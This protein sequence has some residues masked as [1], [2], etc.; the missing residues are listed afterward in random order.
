MWKQ[1]LALR[2]VGPTVLVS[3]LLL[4]L[5]VAAAVYLYGQQATSAAILGENVSSNQVAHDLEA[6]L[7]DLQAAL[8]DRD[9]QLGALHRRAR[10]Q[11]D[12]ARRLADKPR[13]LELVDE[14]EA[15]F[16]HYLE[17]GQATAAATGI[18]E[19]EAL[20]ICRELREFN[21]GLARTSEQEHRRTVQ[22]LA[23]GVAGI[24]GF[25]ALAGLAL[26]LAAARGLRRSIH[27]LSVRVRDAADK[28]GQ[29]L[30]PV[31]LT[32]PADLQ[33]LQ[34]QLHGLV[35]EITQVV[36]KLHQ[37]EREV[38]RAEQLA[39]VGQLAAGVAHELRNPLTSVKLL[40][41]TNRE[42]AESRGMPVEDLDVIEREIHRMEH[43]VQHFLD[44]ARP[45]QPHRRPTDLAGVVERTF[46]L[47]GGRA[48]KQHVELAF[49][50]PAT[51]VRV[52]ADADQ[53][54]QLLVNLAL[55]SLDAMPRGGTLR[56]ELRRGD[57]GCAEL[58]F[59]D[60][61][62]GIAPDLAPH[63]F[64]PFVSSKETGLGLGLVTSRRIA[65]N[66]GGRLTA[67]NVGG[68]GASFLL[69]LP[70][71]GCGASDPLSEPCPT[72]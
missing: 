30:P 38:L 39:A 47:V 19:R 57:E 35:G 37:R 63:L 69:R 20:P 56:A 65:E 6:T 50:P 64:E 9:A 67:Q 3:L 40:V 27:Q 59:S 15:R 33:G 61:G 7:Q 21:T 12:A 5:C 54:Q 46:A 29:D 58:R 1:D 14:L 24:G 48:R 17:A 23:W 70:A 36:E 2:V 22:W 72:C 60:T 44:Y 43:C 8:G 66:H 28:L 41:Q 52:E 42:E 34:D 68:G 49:D 51:P 62:P 4:G 16:R 53:L 32:G 11:L 26:G 25:G 71:G 18:L 31:I 55:N 45:P 10:E 13:E